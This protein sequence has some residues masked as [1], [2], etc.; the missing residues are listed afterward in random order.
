MNPSYSSNRIILPLLLL[1]FSF[2]ALAQPANDDCASAIVLNDVS[3]WCSDVGFYTNV[4]AA[5]AVVATPSCFPITGISHDV[6]FTFTAQANYL[7]VSVNG[8]TT[9]NP[10]GT[11]AF[12]QVAVYEGGCGNLNEIAC[13]SDAVGLNNCETFAGPLIVGQTYYLQVDARNSAEG[14]FQLCVNN[15]NQV[16][17]PS[18]DCITGVILCD[19][20]PFVVDAVVGVGNDPNEIGNSAC[21]GPTCI[22]D[23][24]SSTWYRW[25]CDQPGS[26]TFTLTP[27]NPVDDLDFILYELPGGIDDCSGKQE[28]R[29]M[30]SGENVSSPLSEW[31]DCTG[32]TGLSSSDADL[33]ETCG[34]QPGDNNFV[35]AINMVSGRSYALVINNF[36]NSGS[37]F[38]I[39]FGGTGTFLGPEADFAFN[40][41]NPCYGESVVFTDASSF[42]NGSIVDYQW[43]FG[44]GA[45]PSSASGPGPHSVVFNSI[46]TKSIV[47]TI[48]TDQGCIVT[49]VGT[50][51]IDPC[52]EDLNA[53]TGSAQITDLLCA[54]D[55]IGAVDF[56][57]S[58]NAPPYI[59]S[60]STGDI[61]EDINSLDVGS[62]SVTVINAATCE[63]VFTYEVD[64]PPPLL[65]NPQ[66]VMP[67]CDGGMD[68]SLT[69]S[70]SGGNGGPYLYDWGSGFGTDN[71]LQ[72]I[73]IGLYDLT[74]Q[75]AA[76]CEKDTTLE[77]T[78]LVLELDPNVQA[79]IEPS[80]FGFSDGT[81]L[82]AIANGQPPYQYSF[83]G[84]PFGPANVLTNIPS[85]TY[86]V[87]VLDANNCEGAFEIFVGQPPPLALAV[88][89]TDISCYGFDDGIA[90]VTASGGVGGY[91]YEW[92]NNGTTETIDMLPPGDYSLTVTD[93]NGCTIESGALITE[94]PELF[95]DL[96][97]VVDVLCFGESTGS[98]SVVATGGTPGY[99]YSSNGVF[100][101]EDSVLM[102]LAAGMY[103]LVVQDAN[104]CTATTEAEIDQPPPLIIDAGPDQTIELGF[105]TNI[106][107][108]LSPRDWPVTYEWFPFESLDCPDCPDVVAS[109]VNT[110]T[111][112]VTVRDSNDCTATDD[113]TIFVEKNRPIYIPNV[114]SPNGDGK[115][116]FFTLFGNPAARRIVQLRVYSRWGS[117]VYET[118]DIPL[119]VERLGWDGTFRGQPLTPD[120]FAFYAE[121]EFVDDEVVLY[122][123]DI[124]IVR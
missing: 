116:D 3:N 109:P 98:A 99:E 97:E 82:I 32:P 90:A 40:P 100:F 93:A 111:Y 105:S 55:P 114:F 53:I 110:T 75:D 13:I 7:N 48:E 47:L 66:M 83:N 79:V 16:P 121:V 64:G 6:W 87:D 65:I 84:N 94:P 71:F 30:A 9:I 88:D 41:P 108:F 49:E 59:F 101:Q 107:S 15:Y 20:S 91:Q 26:L 42:V 5:P 21:N 74:I 86:T 57:P 96:L 117:L 25:T 112:Q 2:S 11:L 72:N 61:S 60:W 36:S 12:P 95:L 56:T 39:E 77:V 33:S 120:V 85:G 113:I 118:S 29:C 10:G 123:G 52:C 22:L 76:G 27:L 106:R 8:N 51:V 63:E 58:S 28:I 38:S 43:S 103:T 34:C 104:G 80:C 115:N 73:P 122:E 4:N 92:S 67:T 44:I 37:G 18:G 124:T 81:L 102:N 45:S 62:Y 50:V 119:G 54:D 70:P 78:E 31:I 23:E 24:S 14:T 69:V 89:T 19:K 1:F 17:E 35:N 46:G 68:G